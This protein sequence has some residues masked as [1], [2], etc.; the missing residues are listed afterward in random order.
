MTAISLLPHPTWCP[1]SSDPSTPLEPPSPLPLS[2]VVLSPLMTQQQFKVNADNHLFVYILCPCPRTS[3]S[4]GAC[5]PTTL[6]KPPLHLLCPSRIYAALSDG[7]KDIITPL[8]SLSIHDHQLRRAFR[9]A[10]VSRHILGP[11]T[12]PP[13]QV[14]TDF[15]P[16]PSTLRHLLPHPRSQMF[17]LPASL[18]GWDRIPL[19]GPAG[20]APSFP[21]GPSLPWISSPLTQPHCSGISHSPPYSIN[22]LQIQCV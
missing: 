4:R 6:V 22:C 10:G 13:G 21:P 5:K 19:P 14:V 12:Q 17:L 1:N 9:V 7:E 8:S 15:L 20:A 3:S 18:K 2:P 16:L 11:F